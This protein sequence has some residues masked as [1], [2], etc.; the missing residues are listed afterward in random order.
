MDVYL[1]STIFAIVDVKRAE[2]GP[3]RTIASE[4]Q[5]AIDQPQGLYHVKASLDLQ[6]VVESVGKEMTSAHVKVYMHAS[7]SI[8]NL[9][10]ESSL[11][12]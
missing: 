8:S 3:D 10:Q 4:L 1:L 2:R 5:C 9:L 7:I 12:F 6:A 11:L